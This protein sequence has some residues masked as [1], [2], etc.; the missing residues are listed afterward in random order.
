VT[1]FLPYPKVSK[2]HDL[3]WGT[4]RYDKAEDGSVIA[5]VRNSKQEYLQAIGWA[6]RVDLRSG[7]LTKLDPTRVDC[8]NTALEAD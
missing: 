6:Y 8:F 3:V 7:K 5:V 2:G 4:C 1:D